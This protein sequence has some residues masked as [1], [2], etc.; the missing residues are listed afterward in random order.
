MNHLIYNEHHNSNTYN[1]NKFH[2]RQVIYLEGIHAHIKY[3]IN[4]YSQ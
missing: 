3:T 4:S 2:M 1:V